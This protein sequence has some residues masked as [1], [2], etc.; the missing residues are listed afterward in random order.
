MKKLN[1]CL[2]SALAVMLTC[3][4]QPSGPNYEGNL[5]SAKCDV[6]AGWVWDA[7]EADKALSVTIYDG[8]TILGS[9]K[10]EGFRPDLK[11]A[12]KGNGNHGFFL[13]TPASIKDG[14]PHTIRAK[15]A[16]GGSNWELAGSGQ[17][18]TCG[19]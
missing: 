6:I 9:V 15:I 19:P 11:A 17:A 16:E 3:C 13:A 5:D 12:Q 2:G 18:L 1:L 4:S 7:N 8:E 14:R 10:A